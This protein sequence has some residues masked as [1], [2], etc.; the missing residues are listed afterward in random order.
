MVDHLAG[1]LDTSLAPWKVQHLE[2]LT[3]DWRARCWAVWTAGCS[4]LLTETQRERYSDLKKVQQ[5]GLR[6]VQ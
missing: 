5:T 3:A 6:W 4:V 1:N 2:L